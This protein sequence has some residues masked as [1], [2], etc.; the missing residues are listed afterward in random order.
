MSDLVSW[1]AFRLLGDGLHLSG[2]VFGLCAIWS[3]GSVEGF[4]R[5]AQV[6]FQAVYVSRYLDVLTASQ[7][8]YLLTFKI[9]FNLITAAMLFTFATF[10][11]TYNATADSCN[12]LAI[13]LPTA[14]CAHIAS[15]GTGL[16]EEMWTF[17]E[18]LEPFA[19]VPQYIVCYRVAQVRPA[20]VIYILTLG[21]YR[22]LYVCNWVYKRYK[23]HAAYHDYVSWLGGALE[24]VL[25]VDFVMRIS[26]RDEVIGAV[27]ASPLGRLILDVDSSSSRLSEKIELSTMGRRLPFGLSGPGADDEDRLRKQWDVSDKISDEESCQLLTLAC[28]DDGSKC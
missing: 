2:M 5:K 27:G 23:W 24:C 9:L 12:I 28:D 4:S 10:V 1:N 19:L 18:F 17:S 7:S 20:A 11:H 8:A 16:R 13:V 3:S 21:G 15:A 25:F 26:R 6:L 22:A 14:I